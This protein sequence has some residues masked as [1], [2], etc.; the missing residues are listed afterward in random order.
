MASRCRWLMTGP[1]PHPDSGI[2]YF[3]RATP[4]DVW[5]RRTELEA[6]GIK[7][8]KESHRSLG[9]RDKKE[10][11]R[12]YHLVAGEFEAAWTDWRAMLQGGPVNLEHKNRVA[13]AGEDAR[14]LVQTHEAE[15]L[16]VKWPVEIIKVTCDNV[17]AA[18]GEGDLRA[19][20]AVHELAQELQTLPRLELPERLA[21]LLRTES[22]G[23]RR[24]LTIALTGTLVSYRETVGW[25]RAPS[26]GAAKGVGLTKESRNA[27]G[28]EIAR[29]WG[30]GWETL[31]AYHDGNYS[32]PG[33]IKGLPQFSL[34]AS[35]QSQDAGDARLSLSYLLERK[36]KVEPMRPATLRVWRS[37]IE[38]FAKFIGHDDA[39]RVTKDDT[40]R[41]CDSLFVDFH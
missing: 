31:K 41:W 12:K 20:N 22:N 17:R 5:D 34:K 7:I 8:T 24:T 28:K 11:D 32:E 3:R 13:L 37:K 2:F 40:I 14:A 36:S 29:W 1:W 21:H 26:L 30:K 18:L 25:L 39:R 27:L 6:L 35:V 16:E 9:T 4:K 15:P 23:P 33:W 19:A 38:A 10:A